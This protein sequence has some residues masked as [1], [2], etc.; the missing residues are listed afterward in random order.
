MISENRELELILSNMQCQ[1]CVRLLELLLE[2]AGV[3]VLQIKLGFVRLAFDESMI[4]EKEIISLIQK[5][6][7]E[8]VK[9]REQQLV[10]QIKTTVHELVHLT[11]DN[12]MVRNSDFLVQ[13]FNLSYQYISAIFRKKEDITLEKYIIHQKIRKV[14]DMIIRDEMSLSEIAFI[15]GYSSVQYLSTQFKSICG[16]S[17]SDFKKDPLNFLNKSLL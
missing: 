4:S 5:E 8:P 3:Q 13:K 14:Q 17:V 15:N 7:F 10:E 2:K 9:D 12:A 16:I 6:G 11:T 1:C